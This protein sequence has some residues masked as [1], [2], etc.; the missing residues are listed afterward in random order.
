MM[1]KA[2]REKWC[3]RKIYKVRT[4]DDNFVRFVQRNKK[5]HAQQREKMSL[6]HKND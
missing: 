3:K 1:R 6:L 5:K 4:K 2:M